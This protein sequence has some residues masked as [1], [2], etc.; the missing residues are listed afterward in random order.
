MSS[1][2]E[3]TSHGP[4]ITAGAFTPGPW[5]LRDD[6]M[7]FH[8]SLDGVAIANLTGAFVPA[9]GYHDHADERAANA[10]LIAAAP[11]LLEALKAL[12]EAPVR[13]A[14]HNIPAHHKRIIAACAAI[15]KAEGR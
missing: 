3:Q 1:A 2:T 7:I 10:R 6:L 13:D 12:I 5:R 11:D 15:A 14:T 9:N 4:E 8:P